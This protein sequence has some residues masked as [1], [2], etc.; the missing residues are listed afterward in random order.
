MKLA[1]N[2][3]PVKKLPGYSHMKAAAVARRRACPNIRV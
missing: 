3:Q 2:V 1:K